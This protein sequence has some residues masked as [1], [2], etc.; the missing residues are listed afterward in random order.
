MKVN[1]DSKKPINLLKLF[2][3][4]KR[5]NMMVLETN[6][7]T[8]QEIDKH[9]SLKRSSHLE[10]NK[11]RWYEE[12][13]RYSSSYGMCQ[14]AL[15]SALLVIKWTLWVSSIFQCNTLMLWFWHFV[16][17]KNSP[18]RCLSQIMLLVDQL[19]NTMATIYI[20]DTN[21]SNDE[22]TIEGMFHILAIHKE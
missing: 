14:I 19:N 1:M 17:N 5:V 8:N 22:S 16:E 11:C 13:P 20:P 3:T 7:Y 15:F 18:G 12:F 10:R 6:Q 9:C 2:V 21:I 4:D